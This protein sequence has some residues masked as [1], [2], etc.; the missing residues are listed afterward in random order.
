MRELLRENKKTVDSSSF[1]AEVHDDGNID[2]IR[3]MDE[4][5]NELVVEMLC[6]WAQPW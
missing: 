6:V 1:S 3:P 5:I 4:D 2:L